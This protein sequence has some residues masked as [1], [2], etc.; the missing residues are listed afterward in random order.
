MGNNR[1]RWTA[2]E[3]AAIVGRFKESGLS[4]S[5][6][7]KEVGVSGNSISNWLRLDREAQLPTETA[8]LIPVRVRPPKP[9]D[10]LRV[11]VVLRNG[12]ALRVPQTFDEQALVRLIAVLE[13]C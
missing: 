3:K 5:A 4:Q 1:H 11:E 10:T 13:A 7:A 8:D 9:V 6:F 12:R 2:E